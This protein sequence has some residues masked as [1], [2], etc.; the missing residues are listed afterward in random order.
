MND[1]VS[2]RSFTNVVSFYGIVLGNCCELG[3]KA[4]EKPARTEFISDL[5]LCNKT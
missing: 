3:T 4:N 1:E 2:A 5:F